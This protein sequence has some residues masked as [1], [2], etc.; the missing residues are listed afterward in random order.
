MDRQ[1]LLQVLYESYP[2]KSKVLACKQVVRVTCTTGVASVVTGDGSNYE[3][4][5]IVGADG[6]HSSIRSEM[7]RL[8]GINQLG[9][10]AA[11]EKQSMTVEYS[12]IFGISRSIEG[13]VPGEHVIA[14]RDG[15]TVLTF[16]GKGDRVYWFVIQKLSQ[17]YVYPHAPRFSLDDAERTCL[18]LAKLRIWK[19]VSIVDLWQAREVVSMTALEE[20]IFKTWHYQRLVL[21]GDSVHKVRVNQFSVPLSV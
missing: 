14:Y 8:A 11:E 15:L 1:K 7:W 12:C 5:L 3:G 21:V 17:T 2:D 9:G 13:L 10:V 19:D 20:N 16:P 4:N 6:V 18:E